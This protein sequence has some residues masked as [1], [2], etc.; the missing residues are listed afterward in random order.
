LIIHAAIQPGLSTDLTSIS[1]VN[2]AARKAS[3][4]LPRTGPNT[5]SRNTISISARY[6]ALLHRDLAAGIAAGRAC[7]LDHSVELRQTARRRRPSDEVCVEVDE[8]SLAAA[9]TISTPDSSAR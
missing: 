5:M 4:A 9:A 6:H 8:R 3:S 1:S 7:L 2:D